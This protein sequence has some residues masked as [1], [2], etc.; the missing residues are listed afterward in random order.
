MTSDEQ[1]NGRSLSDPYYHNNSALVSF[2]FTKLN[3]NVS[4]PLRLFPP[5]TRLD[6]EVETTHSYI[7]F[8]WAEYKDTDIM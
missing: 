8:I 2:T 6:A 4:W 1:P 3:K 7:I 5:D